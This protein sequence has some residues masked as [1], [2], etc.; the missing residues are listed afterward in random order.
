ML[1]HRPRPRRRDLSRRTRSADDDDDDD[2]DPTIASGWRLPS[3]KP[4]L[5]PT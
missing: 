2:D 4:Y 3:T 1:S 5:N